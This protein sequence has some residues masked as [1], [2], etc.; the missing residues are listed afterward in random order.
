MAEFHFRLVFRLPE[1][2][3]DGEQ[4]LSAL[5]EQGCDD[6]LVGIGVMGRI[7]LDFTREADSAR[8]AVLSAIDDV[9]RA[10]PGAQLGEVAPDLVGLTDM[11][12]LLGV[13]RQYMRKLL[14]N[15]RAH[16]P[17]PVYES[18][19]ALWHLDVMLRWLRE[20]NLRAVPA[21]LLELAEVTRQCNLQRE[22]RALNP[23]FQ[24]H[25]QA[26]HRQN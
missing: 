25:W 18:A 2:G 14:V 12:T 16:S 1:G 10:I 13:S 19:T 7:G 3:T 9:R 11:A 17:A 5:A 24:S 4:W 21:P 22:M 23:A 8:E 6:A 20:Q 15:R 26:R